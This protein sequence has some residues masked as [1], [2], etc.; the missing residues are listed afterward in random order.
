MQLSNFITI[1]ETI[2]NID[3]GFK[4]LN[5]LIDWKTIKNIRNR[6]VHD[7]SRTDYEVN[8]DV[9][10]N[11]IDDLEFQIQELINNLFLSDTE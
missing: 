5:S 2:S 11:Y 8:I 1:G 7:Y 3:P 9:I 10:S 4:K 6:M